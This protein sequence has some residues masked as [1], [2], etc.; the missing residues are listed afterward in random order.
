MEEVTKKRRGRPRKN[1]V[2]ETVSNVQIVDDSVEEQVSVVNEEPI[3]QIVNDVVPETIN[4]CTEEQLENNVV[5]SFEEPNA[6]SHDVE[7][8][9]PQV[10]YDNLKIEIFD[11]INKSEN[12]D[13]G[14]IHY[15]CHNYK[16]GDKVWVPV[17]LVKNVGSIFG[18]IKAIQLYE[19]KKFTVA[20]V[21]IT[22][23]VS[24]TFKET[25]KVIASEKYVFSNEFECSEKCKYLMSK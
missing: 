12:F 6:P 25:H 23:H 22:N 16:I 5:E 1:P 10:Y 4:E 8:Q 20:S 17:S 15:T 11:K 7:H 3:T 24:Y 14:D 21:S 19:P 18:T 9:D 2:V 13:F